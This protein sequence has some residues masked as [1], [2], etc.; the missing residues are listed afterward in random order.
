MGNRVLEVLIISNWADYHK[1]L[2]LVLWVVNLFDFEDLALYNSSYQ[3]GASPLFYCSELLTYVLPLRIFKLFDLDRTKELIERVV[4]SEGMELVDVALGPGEEIVDAEHFVPLVE[5]PLDE[6]R[7]QEAAPSR[8]EDSLSAVG[9]A[10][11][12]IPL[13]REGFGMNG[14]PGRSAPGL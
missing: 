7:A 8:D 11:H 13:R 2:V 5:Q 10:G 9:Q 3:V 6:M 12:W 4:S 1:T 14:I